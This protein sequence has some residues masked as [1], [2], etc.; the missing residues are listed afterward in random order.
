MTVWSPARKHRYTTA[1]TN[2]F[3]GLDS[4]GPN[5]LGL[6]TP[7]F[8]FQFTI[9]LEW[10]V[11]F[12]GVCAAGLATFFLT[13]FSFLF[14]HRP[15]LKFLWAFSCVFVWVTSQLAFIPIA[16]TLLAAFDCVTLSSPSS[17]HVLRQSQ[18]IVCWETSYHQAMAVMAG[19]SLLLFTMTVARLANVGGELPKVAVYF[20]RTWR[21]DKP[22]LG[23]TFRLLTRR[24]GGQLVLHTHARAPLTRLACSGAVISSVGAREKRVDVC[25]IHP[26]RAGRAGGFTGSGC[27]G[28]VH[29]K[30]AGCNRFLLR[31]NFVPLCP[32]NTLA[33]LLVRSARPYSH[34]PDPSPVSRTRLPLNSPSPFICQT[35][36]MPLALSWGQ[37]RSY[38]RVPVGH[39]TRCCLDRWLGHR[40]GQYEP[41]RPAAICVDR[42][43]HR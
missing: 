29:P 22:D 15:S 4:L 43:R 9:G 1:R 26:P 36:S 30:R 32:R 11:L 5:I 27:C 41:C 23:E 20:W 10:P 7:P 12:W 25:A 17:R 33:Q 2:V 40:C 18:G 21:Y 38:E 14:I 28:V 34:S 37:V 31:R 24:V 19:M 8:Q 6:V 16:R 13:Y 39:F 35:A 42:V 3:D